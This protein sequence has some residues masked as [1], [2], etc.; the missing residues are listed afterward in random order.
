M[1]EKNFKVN[2]PFRD[3]AMGKKLYYICILYNKTL[4]NLNGSLLV[5]LETKP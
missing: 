3:L 4:T 2:G 1:T 5:W